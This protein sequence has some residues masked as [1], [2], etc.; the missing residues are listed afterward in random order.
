MQTQSSVTE[1]GKA[2]NQGKKGINPRG[3]KKLNPKTGRAQEEGRNKEDWAHAQQDIGETDEGRDRQSQ[4]R[5]HRREVWCTRKELQNTDKKL[6]PT[7]QEGG[8]ITERSTL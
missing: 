7:A 5:E 2:Q 3:K 6:H 4:R 8:E 1:A